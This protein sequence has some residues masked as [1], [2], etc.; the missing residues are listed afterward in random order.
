MGSSVRTH[1]SSRPGVS[2]LWG[3]VV[4]SLLIVLAVV[5][6]VSWWHRR[7][8]GAQTNAAVADLPE[9]RPLPDTGPPVAGHPAPDF[10]MIY[11]DGR[12]TRLSE[13]RGRPVLINFWATWCPPCRREMPELIQAYEA[14]RDEG[15]VIL[16]VNVQESPSQALAFA[17]EFGI[18]F[19]II[20]D[21][22]GRVSDQYQ[23]RHLPSSIFIDRDGIIVA[24]WVGALTP[25][26]LRRHLGSILQR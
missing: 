23:V 12:R 15:F 25:S 20:L 21:T 7:A 9:G 3:E 11:P 22:E 5:A 17:E 14:H 2:R 16:A 10:E 8:E 4:L 26:M 18:S 1:G 13:L 19:Q 24:R 6:G